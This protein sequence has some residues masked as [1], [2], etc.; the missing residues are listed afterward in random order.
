[1][2]YASSKDR[3]RRELDG[4]QIELQATDPSEMSLEVI[5]GR[6]AWFHVCAANHNAFPTIF[7]ASMH[8]WLLFL[9]RTW[10]GLCWSLRVCF[11]FM[12]SLKCGYF[13][14]CNAAICW[15]LIDCNA[16]ICWYPIWTII[17]YAIFGCAVH[18]LIIF[19]LLDRDMM[20]GFF[21]SLNGRKLL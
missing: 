1:M 10:D 20:H 7:Y 3:F 6:V 11:W 4:I 19:S 17:S 9:I 18:I 2:L 14:D 13:L 5:N 12:I 21:Y 8:W 16:A 15:Y